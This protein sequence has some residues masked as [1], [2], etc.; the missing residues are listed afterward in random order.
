[1]NLMSGSHKEVKLNLELER[2][3]KVKGQKQ[4]GSADHSIS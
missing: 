1:M 4:K 2:Y 3:F